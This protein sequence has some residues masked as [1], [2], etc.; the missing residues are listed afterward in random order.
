MSEDGGL[1]T[2]YEVGA[3]TYALRTFD[4]VDG[5]LTSIAQGGGHW[6]DGRCAGDLPGP[7]RGPRPQGARGWLQVR[8][9]R[10]LDHR[11]TDSPVR[12]LTPAASSRSS[13]WRASASTVTTG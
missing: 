2:D 5:R 7:S 9:L 11:G 1:P 3:D 10:L 6:Q 4:V 13:A 12:G 8:R